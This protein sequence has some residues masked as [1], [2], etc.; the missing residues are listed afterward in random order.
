MK[1]F[2]LSVSEHEGKYR[3]TRFLLKRTTMS[4]PLIKVLRL[5]WDVLRSEGVGPVGGVEE[6]I[7]SEVL[8]QVFLSL[9]TDS[10]AGAWTQPER[11]TQSRESPWDGS[12]FIV[13]SKVSVSTRSSHSSAPRPLR[14]GAEEWNREQNSSWVK[15]L[16]YIGPLVMCWVNSDVL[17]SGVHGS[18][19]V[20][21]LWTSISCLGRKWS[22][23]LQRRRLERRIRI[24]IR[25]STQL[26]VWA[27]LTVTPQLT[28][29]TPP[30]LTVS[31]NWISTGS[32]LSISL[33]ISL[34]IVGGVSSV[35]HNSLLCSLLSS[36]APRP[37]AL[38]CN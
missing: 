2:C 13:R 32:A 19:G 9:C 21:L 26:K 27:A 17:P 23:S 28:E 18:V 5:F 15:V 36:A 14:R 12:E 31:V 7:G 29:L 25:I 34:K 3:E 30:T 20:R 8:L 24:R 10:T 37:A 38:E 6:V 1:K 35:T 16:S 22:F 11:Q 33:W 4:V